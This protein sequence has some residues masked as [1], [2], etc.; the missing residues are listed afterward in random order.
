MFTLNSCL[1]TTV[2]ATLLLTSTAYAQTEK[3]ADM[4]HESEVHGLDFMPK[5][6]YAATIPDTKYVEPSATRPLQPGEKLSRLTERNK[7]GET[8]LQ[9]LTDRT[10]WVQNNFYNTLFY[11]GDKGVLLMDP[12]GNG[13]GSAVQKAIAS[14]T[15]LPVTAVLYSHDHVD[16]IGD[17]GIFLDTAKATNQSLRI[18]ASDATAA[19]QQYLKSGLPAPTET[20]A[21][22]D[23][24]FKFEN[25]TV[26]AQG[27]QRAA[28]TDDSASWL[29]VEEGIIHAPDM[30]NPDQMA[31][32][33]FGASE[34]AVYLEG[35]LNQLASGDWTYFSG[36]HG[37]I[38]SHADIAFMQAYLVDL[39]KA[40]MD[41][42]QSVDIGQYFN[43][44]L[45]NHQAAAAG[46]MQAVEKQT[47]DTLR[48]K[49]GN[50]YG[51]EASVPFQA[52]MMLKVLGSYR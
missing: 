23:G 44:K 14:V 21:F 24:S 33:S 47:T 11:V 19:K 37:N 27:F 3:S 35:N 18:I 6:G 30:T 22:K 17:V 25:L 2:L 36:G 48:P 16:H 13:V 15:S 31:Y 9:R 10:Y 50:Y 20:V 7:T 29:M 26:K 40:V 12:L 32:L 45:N 5:G 4:H 28:H 49:Y 42:L 41:A 46:W 39:R 52:E 1:A 38:G 34:N 51:F 43:E 8:V